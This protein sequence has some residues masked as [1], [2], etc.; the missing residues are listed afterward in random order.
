MQSLYL[1]ALLLKLA[2]RGVLRRENLLKTTTQNAGIGRFRLYSSFPG[3]KLLNLLEQSL[4]ASLT[5]VFAFQ[6]VPL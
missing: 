5:T 2:W 1:T 4:T 3:A 6:I